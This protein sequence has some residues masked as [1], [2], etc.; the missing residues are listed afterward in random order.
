MILWT[1]ADL[2]IIDV[3]VYGAGLSLEYISLIKLRMSN[4]DTLRPFKIPLNVTGLCIL[5]L[6]PCSVYFAALAGA[7]SSTP[8]TIKPA[9]FAIITLL[10]AEASW[11]L[12]LWRNRANKLY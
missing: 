11:Q 7:F 3:T 6:L 9:I 2:L 4:P 12:L 1:F 8:E 5:L 10:S